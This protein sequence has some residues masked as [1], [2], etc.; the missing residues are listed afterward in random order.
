MP[1]ARKRPQIAPR[2]FQLDAR[3]G[4]RAG[5]SVQAAP[6][7]PTDRI[8][9]VTLVFDVVGVEVAILRKFRR[10]TLEHLHTIGDIGTDVE[11]VGIG[12][13]RIDRVPFRKCRAP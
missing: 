7:G 9:L 2:P 10:D 3:E 1:S 12:Q 8:P 13:E 11:S 4:L 5:T 6:V